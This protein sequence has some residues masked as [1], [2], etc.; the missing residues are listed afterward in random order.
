M[1]YFNFTPS[2]ISTPYQ[3]QINLEEGVTYT[4]WIF[5]LDICNNPRLNIIK[6]VAIVHNEYGDQLFAVKS[7]NNTSQLQ[8]NILTLCSLV[9]L[10]SY[11]IT[12]CRFLSKDHKFINIIL[13]KT[14]TKWLLKPTF[15]DV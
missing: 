11:N 1:Y 12:F 5:H 3:V 4:H 13:G 7:H 10:K 15:H 6:G 9:L 14:S 8:A 2:R